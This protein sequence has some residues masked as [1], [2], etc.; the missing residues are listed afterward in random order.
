MKVGLAILILFFST[1]LYGQSDTS[2]NFLALQ[3]GGQA[4]V[5]FS[6]DRTLIDQSFFKLNAATGLV[7]NEYANDT[8]P[9]DRPIK[10]LNLGVIGLYDIK[11]KYVFIESGFYF[12]PYYYKS[13]TFINFYGWFGLRINSK[14]SDGPF[15]SVG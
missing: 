1:G 13:L 15:A 5:G 12:S 14:T 6:Y 4:I 11:I 3:F 9:S 2:K 8:D 7:I 10:G